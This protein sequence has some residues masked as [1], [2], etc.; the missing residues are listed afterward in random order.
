[1]ALAEDLYERVR[2]C[3]LCPL[4]RTRTLAVPGEGPL[5]AEVLFIGEAPGVNEDRQGRPF[6]GAA[7]Q[8]LGELLA[9]ANLRR[10]DVYICNVLKCRP[11]ANR[12]PLPGEIEACRDYLDEQIEMV[13]PRVI[14]T[15]GRS[16]M[17]R[18]FPGESIS[19]IHG[20]VR[21]VDGRS[22]VPMYHPAAALHQ[23]NLR[24]VILADFRKLGALLERTRVRAAE[25]PLGAAPRAVV[26]PAPGVAEALAA[27]QAVRAEAETA[28]AQARLFE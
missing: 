28:G 4:A 15:L 17:G 16:S 24:E 7:G 14:V 11:P 26:A 18:Y 2:T 8:F 6:V 27:A 9:A 23:Q 10:E 12:D 20:S 22:C 19:R 25:A 3:E 13:D 21:E 5:D 1:M